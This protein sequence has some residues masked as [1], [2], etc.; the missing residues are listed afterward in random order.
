MAD[1]HT[2]S[3]ARDPSYCGRDESRHAVLAWRT[4]LWTVKQDPNLKAQVQGILEQVSPESPVERELFE[5]LQGVLVGKAPVQSIL[6]CS[7]EQ[8]SEAC[9]AATILQGATSQAL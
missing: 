1:N 5:T 9:A 6:L 2:V 3:K 4:I 8:F 7:D